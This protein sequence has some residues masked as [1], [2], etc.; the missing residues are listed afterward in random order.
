[1]LRERRQAH[2]SAEAV[3]RTLD[4]RVWKH[5]GVEIRHCS[6]GLGLFATRRFLP[7]Q[8]IYSTDWLTVKGDVQDLFAQ[9]IVDGHVALV[10]VTVEHMVVFEDGRWLDVPGCFANH[11]CAPTT[12]SV[13]H[14][15]AGRGRVSRYDQVALV[16]LLPGDE[17]TC[18][19]TR[20]DWGDDGLAFE[21]LCGA[22]ACYGTIDGFFGLPR[23]LQEQGAASISMEALRR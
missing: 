4:A 6:S 21:C 16:E 17:L 5:D 14:D 20:F 19:Y 7:G 12:T 23:P 8:V 22:P 10:M 9:T 15:P 18:D 3:Q 2:E 1:M 13:F 11:S